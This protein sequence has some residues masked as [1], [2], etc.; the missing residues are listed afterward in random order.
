MIQPQDEEP[1]K[2][3]SKVLTKEPTELPT[4]EPT[5]EPTEE[6]YMQTIL[7]NPNIY[8]VLFKLCHNVRNNIFYLMNQENFKK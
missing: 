1:P 8:R 3:P 2:E 7:S 4:K 6:Q 5:K